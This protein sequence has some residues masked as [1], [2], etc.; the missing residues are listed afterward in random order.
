MAATATKMV[1][2]EV[3]EPSSQWLARLPETLT[4]ALDEGMEATRRTLK[5]ARRTAEDLS[6]EAVHAV[7]KYPL[8]SVAVTFGVAVGLGTLT[9]WLLTRQRKPKRLLARLLG[10]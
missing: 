5:Q 8:Q 6:E 4:Q 7:K 1:T 2:K 3:L 10:R 9:G